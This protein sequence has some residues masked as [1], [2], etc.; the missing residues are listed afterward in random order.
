VLET[1]SYRGNGGFTILEVVIAI[2]ILAL[3]FT[4]GYASLSVIQKPNPTSL[5]FTAEAT[6]T[7]VGP[8]FNDSTGVVACFEHPFMLYPDTSQVLCLEIVPADSA[9][10][11]MVDKDIYQQ[12]QF[13]GKIV[14]PHSFMPVVVIDS[15]K[16][17]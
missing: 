3:I 16:L 15:L 8:N 17:L 12:V 7:S 1:K 2:V 9:W 4:V 14:E 6:V 5:D 10:H 13:W 11:I